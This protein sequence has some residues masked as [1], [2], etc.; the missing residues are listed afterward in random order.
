MKKLLGILLAVACVAHAVL[1]PTDV[2]WQE[3]FQT[4]AIVKLATL[5]GPAP[6]W[7]PNGGPDGKSGALKFTVT[8]PGDSQWLILPLDKEKIKG[9]VAIEGDIKGEEVYH[10]GATYFGPRL[11]IRSKD[12]KGRER[13]PTFQRPAKFKGTYGW[14]HAC[15]YV[16][17]PD[18][19]TE[20]E[21]RI[22]IM[23]GKG[24]AYFSNI[25]I[26]K[27]EELENRSSRLHLSTRRP[28]PSRAA[29][30]KAPPTAA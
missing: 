26:R 13:M 27:V 18:D 21:L 1:Y 23:H 22:G 6:Q 30:T 29:R 5:E 2:I 19:P 12:P 11:T 8:T 17:L 25:V 14:Q 16:A 3:D 7:L 24:T 10:V 4:D 9:I 28:R 15:Y 20:L